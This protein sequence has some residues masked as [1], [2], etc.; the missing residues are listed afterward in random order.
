MENVYNIRLKKNLYY[1]LPDSARNNVDT[2]INKGE[3]A[4]IIHLYYEDTVNQYFNYIC[5][6]PMNIDVYISVS[7]EKTKLRIEE[8]IERHHLQNC[9]IIEKKNRGRDI[10]AL[11]V[12]CREIAMQ[13]EYICFL[14]DKKEKNE[15]IKAFTEEW[16]SLMWEN[17]IASEEFI[18]NIKD[19]FEK[20][21]DIG[22]LTVPEPFGMRENGAFDNT[23]Y[24][25]FEKT[26]SLANM[27]K[28]DC[29]LNEA[30]PP[31]TL[32]TAFWAK[33]KALE[34][35]LAYS[36][37]YEDFTEEPLPNDGTINHAVERIIA[38]V[39]Q[40]AGYNIGTVRTIKCAEKHICI[41]QHLLRIAF[42]R[43]S[44]LGIYNIEDAIN[45]ERRKETYYSFFQKYEN[46]YLYGAGEMG[47]R[48]LHFLKLLGLQPKIFLVT[49]DA[50]GFSEL[51]GV[52]IKEL[53]QVEL[54]E[55]VGII[56]TVGMKYKDEIIG[57]LKKRGFH[58][59][60]WMREGENMEKNM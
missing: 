1:V 49:S 38:Y 52:P 57:L 56:I 9:K 43:M 17:T 28:L 11:L 31:I 37:K 36:W 10:S 29:D 8:N 30:C 55:K 32:G 27:L 14:H 47:E 54:S 15:Y 20:H 6:I 2:V 60:I 7:E 44:L 13:Y 39:A 5:N 40:D 51:G 53:E 21:E 4:V 46:V 24:M 45:Y 22:I 35:L 33:T 34:K 48:T 58:N 19:V 59:Y 26:V 41:M 23:W 50:V 18:Y 12:A 25:N 3:V 42:E 16:I